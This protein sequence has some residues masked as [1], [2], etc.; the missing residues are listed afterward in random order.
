MSDDRS[1]LL[2]MGFSLPKVTQALKSSKNS[3][4]QPALEWL[5]AHV[6]DPDPTP[7]DDE[8][9]DAE[10]V[11]VPSASASGAEAKV[12]PPLSSVVPVSGS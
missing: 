10:I 7:D 11:D 2:D 1:Q 12:S 9:E 5:I 6:D 4:L 3:G 8:I